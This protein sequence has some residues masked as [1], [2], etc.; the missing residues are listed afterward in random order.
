MIDKFGRSIHRHELKKHL[1]SHNVIKHIFKQQGAREAIQLHAKSVTTS[2]H[3]A[4]TSGV[5]VARSTV[6]SKDFVQLVLDLTEIYDPKKGATY[7]YI[8]NEGTILSLKYL[9][10][11]PLPRTTE[12]AYRL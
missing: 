8:I 9:G 1:R 3:S 4:T 12:P 7:P 11:G 5:P 10:P 6:Q 2:A